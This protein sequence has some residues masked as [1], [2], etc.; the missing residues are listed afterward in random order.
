MDHF[1]G[2]ERAPS[3]VISL[4]ERFPVKK[5]LEIGAGANPTLPPSWLKG[6]PLEYTTNDVS[7]V[8]LAKA[9]DCYQTF[10]H[11]FTDPPPPEMIG[12]FDLVFSRMVNEHVRHGEAYHRNLHRLLAPGGIAAHWYSTL[13][14]FP[15]LVNRLAPEALTSL[16]LRIFSPRDR[17]QHDKF[18]AYYSW[19]RGP[20]A[21]MLRRFEAAGYSVLEFTGFFGHNYY[22]TLLPWLHAI[23]RRKAQWLVR[24]PVAQLTAYASVL[25][26]KSKD[27]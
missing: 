2:W 10:C 7:R 9:P 18:K 19:S 26:Q 8:E 23:E 22:R 5:V 6:R 24:H 4:L 11:D 21:R 1:G 3:A 14:A 12:Q 17:Y 13:Y 25:L 20:S 15:F 16:L 27:P